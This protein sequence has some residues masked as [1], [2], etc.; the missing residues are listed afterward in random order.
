MAPK[1]KSEG[2]SGGGAPAETVCAAVR[3]H[4]IVGHIM[5]TRNKLVC[6][7]QLETG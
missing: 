2:K 4:E 1:P 5:G 3:R 6:K 7:L